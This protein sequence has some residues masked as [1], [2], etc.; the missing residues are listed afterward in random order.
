MYDLTTIKLTNNQRTN[1][2]IQNISKSANLMRFLFIFYLVGHFK[3]KNDDSIAYT[4]IIFICGLQINKA[5]S[6]IQ[7]E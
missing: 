6:I 4:Y 1:A 5:L 3:N 7:I 2:K